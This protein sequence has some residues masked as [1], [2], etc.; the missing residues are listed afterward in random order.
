[1]A[2]NFFVMPISRYIPGAFIIPTMQFAWSLGLRCFSKKTVSV[3]FVKVPLLFR[4]RMELRMKPELFWL[5]LTATMTALL[6]V[7]YVLNRFARGGVL[8]AFQTPSMGAAPV[9]SEWALRAK[10][11]HSNAVENLVV[12]AT[13]ALTAQAA[14]IS[15]HVTAMAAMIYFWGRLVH[16]VAYSA[17]IPYLRSLGWAAGLVAQLMVASQLLMR[18]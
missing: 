4:F 13:L 16:Y 9:E 17:G 6:F 2:I 10:R 8:N 12:F 14:G 15:N 3:A 7:P 18:S 5:A 11:A 1:M